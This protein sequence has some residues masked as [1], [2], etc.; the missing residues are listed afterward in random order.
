MTRLAMVVRSETSDR[1][2]GI[3]L[4]PEPPPSPAG[5]PSVPHDGD[6]R[7][8]KDALKKGGKRI[9]PLYDN[10][11]KTVK[12]HR[13]KSRERE[14][15]RD[16]V[17]QREKLRLQEE[18]SAA[19]VQNSANGGSDSATKLQADEEERGRDKTKEKRRFYLRDK[20]RDKKKN[21]DKAKEKNEK[22]A[23][24]EDVTDIR[25][26]RLTVE[27]CDSSRPSSSYSSRDDSAIY[28]AV[29]MLSNRLTCPPDWA[30]YGAVYGAVDGRGEL[31]ESPLGR[32]V[33]FSTAFFAPSSAVTFPV[34]TASPETA[35]PRPVL[36][37]VGDVK[38][39]VTGSAAS[40]ISP[41]R[42]A[43]DR[44]DICKPC[45][46]QEGFARFGN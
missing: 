16:I 14:K 45:A 31:Y 46:S 37:R 13:E 21:K 4:S 33:S 11:S 29:E 22:S 42:T 5:S 41:S 17:R 44:E 36:L 2:E 7:Q 28:G 32:E 26:Q 20:S 34:I 23:V 40:Q 10:F 6:G 19:N 27:T 8:L 18:E 25:R 39:I 3:Q 43:S 9:F 24:E 30:E 38:I 12:R 15:S 35:G 1:L